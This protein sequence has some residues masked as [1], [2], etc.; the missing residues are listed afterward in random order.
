MRG[1]LF[2]LL[3]VLVAAL[4]VMQCPG[5]RPADEAVENAAPP[6]PPPPPDTKLPM[7][8]LLAA[9]GDSTLVVHR[10]VVRFGV[11]AISVS[12]DDAIVVVWTEPKG[13]PRNSW[14]LR[15]ADGQPSV[16]AGPVNVTLLGF[17]GAS[18]GRYRARLSLDA[19]AAAP[20]DSTGHP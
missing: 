14:T 4:A 8:A 1:C 6:P 18:E 12:D 9:G 5:N 15:T 13:Q 2:F 7:S 10:K 3:L 19:P 16:S 17:E 11:S 20:G